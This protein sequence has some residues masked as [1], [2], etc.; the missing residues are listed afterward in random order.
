VRFHH[1]PTSDG[2]YPDKVLNEW[3]GWINDR[4]VADQTVWAFFNNDWNTFA[5]ANAL[6]LRRELSVASPAIS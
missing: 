2:N 5:P 3:S 4:L 1:G 6:T